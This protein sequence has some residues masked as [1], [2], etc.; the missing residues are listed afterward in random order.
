M[1]RVLKGLHAKVFD[2]P[3]YITQNSLTPIVDYMLNPERA[4]VF[5][6][7]E[8]Q[9]PPERADYMGSEDRYNKE[10]ADYYRVDLQTKTGYIDVEGTLVN[11]AGQVQACVELTSYESLNKRLDAQ[12]DLGIEKVVLRFDSGGGEAYRCFASALAFKEKAKD[13]GV[14]IIAYVDG[15]S[16]S[17]SYAWTVIA[18]EVIANP[19]ALVGSVGVVIQLYNDSQYLK[20]LGI[21][22]SFVFA[23]DNKIPF[24][25]EGAFTEEFIQSLQNRVDKS[26]NS[27]VKH[28]AD[29]RGLSEEAVRNTKA[30]V[31]DADKALELGFIDKIMELEEFSEY[32]TENSSHNNLNTG[33]MGKTMSIQKGVVTQAE[34]EDQSQK[35]EALGSEITGLNQK[36]KDAVIAKEQAEE[37]L[38]EYKLAEKSK[39]RKQKLEAVFG[40]E[41][42][43]VD[44]YSTM[45]ASLADEQFEAFVAELGAS[46]EEKA[47]QMSEKGHD[48]RSQPIVIDENASLNELA[49]QRG[50]KWK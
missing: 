16:A 22:R 24:D 8:V 14:K 41:S 18:D 10:L 45:F 1:K 48:N 50:N 6:P 23:G 40:K 42:A 17:A 20:D 25:K 36:L 12:I 2:K 32:L 7:I 3:L 43:K 47:E 26:Y 19:Q 37:T 21:E 44:A 35:L 13:N 11:K 5:E 15:L 4:D 9:S 39:A 30:S 29:N 28:V 33:T 46:R 31:F 38:S 27:F 49:T 34:F